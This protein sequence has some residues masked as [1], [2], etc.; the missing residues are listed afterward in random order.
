MQFL[1]STLDI[2]TRRS[3]VIKT[4]LEPDLNSL[5]ITSRSFWSISPCW[6]LQIALFRKMCRNKNAKCRFK[7]ISGTDK[8][9]NKSYQSRNGEV[10][11]MHLLCQPVYFSPGVEEYHRLGDCQSFIQITQCVQLPLLMSI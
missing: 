10:P 6:E 4:L 5:I 11:S 8:A 2:L 9:K 1:P 3:V 7:R